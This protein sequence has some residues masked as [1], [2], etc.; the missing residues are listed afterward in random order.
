MLTLLMLIPLLN[1]HAENPGY[2]KDFNYQ[3]SEVKTMSNAQ[4][5]EAIMSR[6]TRNRSICAN[7]AHFWAHDLSRFRNI[8]AGKIFIHFTEGNGSTADSDW[9]YHV[10]PYVMVRGKEM[11]LDP[12]FF[13]FGGKPVALEDWTN[14]FAKN[15]KCVVLDPTGNPAHLE[16]EKYNLNADWMNPLEYKGGARMYPPTEGTCYI[17]KVPMYYQFPAEIYG[18]DLYHSGKM[19]YAQF[20]L[21]HFIDGSVLQACQQAMNLEFKSKHSCDEYL[22]P[23]PPKKED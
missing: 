11:V 9:T 7:R 4:A 23:K 13:V 1:A 12:V 2:L 18:V 10:A 16:L 17:R 15:K 5:L 14:H 8:N 21:N 20:E 3:V 22:N 19:E 6:N